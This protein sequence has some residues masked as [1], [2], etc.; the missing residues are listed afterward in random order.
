MNVYEAKKFLKTIFS[1]D[2]LDYPLT[3]LFRKPKIDL[4]KLDEI[5]HSKFFYTEKKHGSMKSF[6]SKKFGKTILY[7]IEKLI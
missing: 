5:L 6:I 3:I 2:V 7:R 4:L 1:E